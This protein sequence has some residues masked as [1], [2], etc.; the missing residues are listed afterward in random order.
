V[1]RGV[2]FSNV[3]YS[4]E[5]DMVFGPLLRLVGFVLKILYNVFFSWWLNPALDH[6]VQESFASEIRQA[7]PFLFTQ[8][9]GKVVPSPRPEAQS[10]EM[11]YVSIATVNLVFEFSRWRN[12]NYAVRVS[13]TVAPKD[14]YDLIDALRVVEP[15]GQTILSPSVDGWRLFARLLEPRFLLLETAFNQEKFGYA[16]QKLAQLRLGKVPV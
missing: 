7:F 15:A 12:E 3:A 1:G 8:Y 5:N 16:K 10:P 13:P 4:T 2:D 14:S 9:R 11:A 6:W